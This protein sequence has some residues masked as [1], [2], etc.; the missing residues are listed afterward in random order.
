LEVLPD[1][2]ANASVSLQGKEP[3]YEI[4]NLETHT[5]Y[6]QEPLS[7]IAIKCFGLFL[8]VLPMYFLFYTALHLARLPVVTIVNGSPTAF[9]KQI[10]H[11]VQLPF[12][13]IALEFSALWGIFRPLEGRAL[14]ATVEKRLH[15]GKDT[16]SAINRKDEIRWLEQTWRA[17]SRKENPETFYLAYCM[18]PYRK[19]DAKVEVLQSSQAV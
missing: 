6:H 1:G 19:S 12:Y 4:I 15:G 7:V 16:H 13:F 10:W 17:L 2:W 5:R 14:F 8:V 9:F 11:L 18:Q 3:R